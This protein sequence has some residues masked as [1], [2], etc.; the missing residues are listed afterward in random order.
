VNNN[1]VAESSPQSGDTDIT[2]YGWNNRGQLVSVTYYATYSGYNSSTATSTSDYAYDAFGHM[3]M[4]DPIGATEYY[5]NDGQQLELLVNSAGQVTE[6]ELT[7][8]GVDQ[9]FGGEEVTPGSGGGTQSSG[10]INWLLV[11]SDGSGTDVAEYSSGSTSVVDSIVY[12]SF[13]QITYQTTPSD[14]P[15]FTYMGQRYDSNTGLYYEGSGSSWYS[16]VDGV[17]ASQ[18]APGYNGSANNPFEYM[19]NNPNMSQSSAGYTAGD[20]ASGVGITGSGGSAVPVYYAQPTTI[21]P[22]VV[23][24]KSPPSPTP[25]SLPK[26]PPTPAPSS[27]NRPPTVGGAK[28]PATAPSPATASATSGYVKTPA[29]ANQNDAFYN[30]RIAWRNLGLAWRNFQRA[31]HASQLNPRAAVATGEL[32]MLA[33]NVIGA[34]ANALNAG[35]YYWFFDVNSG[36]GGALRNLL[37]KLV[38]VLG[39]LSNLEIASGN[40][41]RNA[42]LKPIN[43][44]SQQTLDKAG[45][46]RDT[47]ADLLNKVIADVGPAVGNLINALGAALNPI[48]APSGG[49]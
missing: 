20:F 30:W 17:F 46:D 19:G 44:V 16:A 25:N 40:Y 24:P 9:V 23:V 32:Q 45:V 41:N 8:P 14:Q 15:T 5:I 47:A 2:I 48:S 36:V 35:I 7:A 29:P 22:L 12:D 37:L 42:L 49:K 13:G 11:N 26:P 18:G 28:A 43:G 1:G 27:F 3:V 33:G 6:R 38:D 21:P 31:Q 10:T 34:L 4:S 39:L